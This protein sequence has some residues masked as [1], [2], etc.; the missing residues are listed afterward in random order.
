MG[1]FFKSKGFTILNVFIICFLG[2]LIFKSR[3][4]IESLNDEINEL[5]GRITRS[6]EKTEKLQSGFEY[7]ESDSYLERQAK[8]KLN[9]KNPGENVAYIVRDEEKI[10]SKSEDIEE[11]DFLSDLIERIFK[12]D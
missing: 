9:L 10:A 5:K 6:D 2:F 12:R 3:P 1:N 8:L 4:I 11:K 7:F